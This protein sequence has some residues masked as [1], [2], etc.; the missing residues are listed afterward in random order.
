MVFADRLVAITPEGD[1]PNLSEDG[2]REA[3]RRFE[4]AFASGNVVDFDVIKATGGPL[5][6]WTASI[7]FGGKDL[8]TAYLGG[9]WNDS[10]PSFRSPVAGL[11]SEERR[12]GKECVSTC[13][14]RWWPDT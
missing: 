6:T 5:C 3:T 7:T 12:V 8:K 9:L 4:D 1:L 10:I 2:D 14:S 11:R 13:R